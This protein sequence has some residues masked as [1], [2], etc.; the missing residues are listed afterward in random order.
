MALGTRPF[1][2][3]FGKR[4]PKEQLRKNKKSINA[5]HTELKGK[6]NTKEKK[7]K[8]L[9]W[10]IKSLRKY[11][12]ANKDADLTAQCFRVLDE[13]RNLLDEEQ[14]CEF[15]AAFHRFLQDEGGDGDSSINTTTDADSIIDTDE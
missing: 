5:V 9:D 10:H 7:T 13:C 11:L 4:S 15:D 6:V 2:P 3:L 8:D 1:S 12:V 14:R